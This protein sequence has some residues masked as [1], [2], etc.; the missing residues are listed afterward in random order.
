M[1]IMCGAVYANAY[2]LVTIEIDQGV[3]RGVPIAVVPF[4]ISEDIDLDFAVDNVIRSDLARTGKFDALQPLEFLSFPT[5]VQDVVFNDWKLI[6]A[7]YLLIGSV[8]SVEDGNYQIVTRLYDTFEGKQIFGFQYS[9]KLSQIRSTSHQI[10]DTVFETVTGRKSSFQSRILYT[11]TVV[12]ENDEIEHRLYIADYDGYNPQLV[13]VEDAPILS[14]AWSPDSLQIAYSVLRKGGIKFF[15]QSVETGER[16][17]PISSQWQV[18]SP[19]W[20]PDG[21]QIALAG[22]Y[23][24]NTDVFLYSINQQN[25]MRITNHPQIDTE[26]AWSPDGKHI[27]FTSNRGKGAQIYRVRVDRQV[28]ES[29]IERVTVDSNFNGGAKYSPSGEN[30]ALITGLE[31]GK[32]VA[33]FDFATHSFNV[34]SKTG[35]DESVNYSPNGDMLMYVV[36]G[37]DRHIRTLSLDGQV[38]SRIPIAD[39]QV[40]QVA[41]EM[42]N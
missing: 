5:T 39:G 20:S 1:A 29:Q 32:R 28:N 8:S 27:V 24:G 33:I 36:E 18:S 22:S 3:K 10:A 26:P 40:K 41:W 2:A 34:L 13:L 12:S 9:V 30:L 23:N 6:G 16:S 25:L 37:A 38:Q 15:V 19:S 4:D 31:F 11:T 17:Q 42:N 35:L 21:Q 14:P 7:D